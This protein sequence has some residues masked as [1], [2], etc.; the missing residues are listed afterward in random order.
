MHSGV[1]LGGPWSHVLETLGP[2]TLVSGTDLCTS[3]L[4]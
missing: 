2:G 1:A 3:P 4:P